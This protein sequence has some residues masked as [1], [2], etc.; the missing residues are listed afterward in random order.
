ML[1]RRLVEILIGVIVMGMVVYSIRTGSVRGWRLYSRE[2]E[3]WTFWTSIVVQAG[4]G[5]CFLLGF[6]SWKK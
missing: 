5:A 6:V 2:D 1:A 4:I 3:P